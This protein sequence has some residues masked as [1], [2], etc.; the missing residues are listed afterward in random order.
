[1]ILLSDIV[2]RLVTVALWE[3]ALLVV[4]LEYVV[5]V[6]MLEYVVQVAL[7]EYVVQVAL[8]EYI[9]QVA[10]LAYVVQVARVGL[11]R[12]RVFYLHVPHYSYAHSLVYLD[13][14]SC[15]E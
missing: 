2:Q 7:L 4:L 12:S 14:N 9:A 13:H 10:L 1:M 3:Y 8:L 15:Y 11:A 5:Q 6:A